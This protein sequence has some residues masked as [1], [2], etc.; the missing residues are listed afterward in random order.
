[1]NIRLTFSD[2]HVPNWLLQVG[3]ALSDAA[4]LSA[5]FTT[6]PPL[7][8]ADPFRNAALNAVFTTPLHLVAQPPPLAHTCPLCSK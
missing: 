8:R 1:M 7:G 6:P 3:Y 5:L 4:A 2:S